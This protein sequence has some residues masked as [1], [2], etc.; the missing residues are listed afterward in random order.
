MTSESVLNYETHENGRIVVM[1]LN[2]PD[3]MNALNRDLREAI[4]ESWERF[5]RDDDAWVAIVTGAGRAF[6][7]GNDLRERRDVAEGAV[8]DRPPRDQYWAYPLAEGLDLW[9]P[10]IAAV[11]GFALA[12]GF[13][14]AMQCDI[15]I[16]S[17]T[18][19]FGI[20]ETRWNRTASWLH[21]LP[22]Q[23]P[24]QQALELALWG[25]ARM[26]AQRAYQ[27]GWVTRV[28]PPEKLMEEAYSWA[29]RQLY[30]APRAV[31]NFKQVLY[32]SYYLSPEIGRAFSTALQQ[33]QSGMEDSKEGLR[34]FAE[35]R[36]PMFQNR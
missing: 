20:A 13:N 2:R 34:A 19:E 28:V 5:A 36:P 24:L 11:N 12:G 26:S 32:R 31:R 9:K 4:A 7:A 15:R 35:K 25:D 30:L 6:C 18:A 10:T 23:M 3:R 29:K 8:Q 14:L 16:A 1:T 22:R 21:N 27:I 17:E 33:D